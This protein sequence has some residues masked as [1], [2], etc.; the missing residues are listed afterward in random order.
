MLCAG[1]MLRSGIVQRTVDLSESS[2]SSI[3]Q[4][5]LVVQCADKTGLL[6][7]IAQL[8]TAHAHNIKVRGPEPLSSGAQPK[9]SYRCSEEQQHASG[10]PLSDR[11]I[12]RPL[13]GFGSCTHS[14]DM[15]V[16][17]VSRHTKATRT[18]AAPSG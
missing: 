11:Q 4:T 6:A 10:M 13:V 15:L 12:Q 8:I 2:S 16:R 3:E 7:E 18:R 9:P 5:W 1:R 17:P 14:A